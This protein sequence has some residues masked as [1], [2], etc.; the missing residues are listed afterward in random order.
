M[1]PPPPSPSLT[2]LLQ[3]NQGSCCLLI[4]FALPLQSGNCRLCSNSECCI[5]NRC[6]RTALPP[7]P[8]H[9]P[10]LLF[11]IHWPSLHRRM[12]LNPPPL[13]FHP[14]TTRSL[15]ADPL[16][17]STPSSHPPIIP[18]LSHLA[19]W[20]PSLSQRI[21]HPISLPAPP[22]AVH[23]PTS[24][25]TVLP[26]ARPSP[27]PPRRLTHCG[28]C[29]VIFLALLSDGGI[30]NYCCGEIT[31]CIGFNLSM[32]TVWSLT[33]LG[34]G[35]LDWITSLNS[36]LHCDSNGNI[37]CFGKRIYT[38]HCHFVYWASEGVLCDYFHSCGIA[39]LTFLFPMAVLKCNNPQDYWEN[40]NVKLLFNLFGLWFH[41]IETIKKL[42]ISLLS[43]FKIP[44]CS[45]CTVYLGDRLFWVLMLLPDLL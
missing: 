24:L 13:L 15:S 22:V 30:L 37:A 11:P 29:H 3:I 6:Q 8:V 9:S 39:R 43:I 41:R 26:I 44:S 28:G 7:S 19:S 25:R 10:P 45:Q 31:H 35:S 42:A 33:I 1:P 4:P 18:S 40:L 20:S 23:Q 14:F 38:F 16:L 17:G 21:E 12:H 32:G 5:R 2:S 34:P 27:T 36:S